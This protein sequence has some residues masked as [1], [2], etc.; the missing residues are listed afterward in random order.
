MSAKQFSVE[1]V[2]KHDKDGDLWVIIDAKVYDLSKFVGMHPGGRSALLD[3]EVAGKDATEAFFSLH[4]YEVLQKPQY[5]RLHIGSVVGQAQ[6]IFPRGVG[7][8]SKVPY[9]EPTWMTPGFSSPY[10]KESHRNLLLAFRKFVEEILVPDA[11]LREADGKRPDLNVYLEMGKQNIVAMRLGPGPH[12]KGRMLMGGVVKPEEF[13]YFHEL[14]MGAEIARVHSRGYIDGSGG[15]TYI[16]LP[17]IINFG[18]PALRNK[19]VEEV[20]AG[21]KFCALAITEAF[22]GSDVAGL[23]CHSKKVEGGWIVN[24]TCKWIT[25]GTFAEYFVV[26]C[27]T[28]QGSLNVLVVERGPGV[29][30]KTIKTSYSPT[31]GTAYVTFDDVFVPEENLLGQENKGLHVILSNFNHERWGMITASVGNQR[32]IVEECLKWVS[33]R[34]VF[35]KPLHSQAVIRAK[36]AGMISRVESVQNWLE[37]VTYQMNHMKYQEQAVYL[38]GPIALLKKYTTECAQDTARDAIQIFGG[39]G[40]TKS[41]MGKFIERYH[42]SSPFDAVLGGAEDVLGDLGVRQALRRMPKDARL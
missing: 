38:A 31:A 13:D 5:K 36:L 39:R 42:L 22:A 7:E 9:A 35:G 21:R 34:K 23:R 27:R 14:I 24:G 18:T 28:D 17:P 12:L 15:G 30:T 1:E 33:Q 26:G 41:G 19:V 29:E 40:I 32:L 16:G 11:E 6:Q 37:S 3:E 20:F 10:Y 8:L 4:R 25:N 2:A